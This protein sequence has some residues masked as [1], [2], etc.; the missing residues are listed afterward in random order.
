MKHALEHRYP[1]SSALFRLEFQSSYSV[2]DGEVILRLLEL[3]VAHPFPG[4][5][6]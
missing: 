4:E 5:G 6:N 3:A 2:G 1:S